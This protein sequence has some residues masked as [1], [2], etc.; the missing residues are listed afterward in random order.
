MKSSIVSI[1]IAGR[2]YAIRAT[3]EQKT[4]LKNA[5]EKLS[6]ALKDKLSKHKITDNRDLIAMV[7]FD[8]YVEQEE[9]DIKIQESISKLSSLI[10]KI[11]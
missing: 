9:K 1:K 8:L 2:E 11:P 10:K 7:L 5:E 6:L 3:D 4:L